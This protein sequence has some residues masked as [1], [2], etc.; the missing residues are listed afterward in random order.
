MN[1]SYFTQQPPRRFPFGTAA[2]KSTP[3]SLQS[4]DKLCQ[5]ISAKGEGMSTFDFNR[6]LDELVRHLQT[7]SD[8]EQRS[9]YLSQVTVT[10]LEVSPTVLSSILDHELFTLVRTRLVEVLKQ[11]HHVVHLSKTDLFAFWNITKLLRKLSSNSVTLRAYSSWLSDS[12][13]LETVVTSLNDLATTNK[14]FND[15]ELKL[16]IRLL[17]IYDNCQD[18]LTTE[19]LADQ[20]RFQTAL[21]PIVKCLTCQHVTDAF[22]QLDKSSDSMKTK[23]KFF[24]IKCSNFLLSC[25]GRYSPS[26][27]E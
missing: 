27:R 7:I 19:N 2:P 23:E 10:L 3:T 14:Y 12:Q 24:L 6:S 13:L 8:Q 20:D 9:N 26:V 21:D 15:Q 11:W 25:E 16:F 4:I 1:P 22:L 5:R 17:N 18:W